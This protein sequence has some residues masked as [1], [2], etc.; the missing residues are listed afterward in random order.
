MTSN[1][2]A[3]LNELP[4]EVV[5]EPSSETKQNVN[6]QYLGQQQQPLQNS[7]PPQQNYPQAPPNNRGGPRG[8]Q[9]DR[10]VPATAQIDARQFDLFG[11]AEHWQDTIAWFLEVYSERDCIGLHAVTG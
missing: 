7:V 4:W 9:Q 1:L 10:P 11:N 3:R 2:D 8:F 6:P 5:H